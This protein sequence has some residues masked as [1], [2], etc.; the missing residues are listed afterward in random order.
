MNS[1]QRFADDCQL[2][3]LAILLA[4]PRL[5]EGLDL[6][7]NDFPDSECAAL[8]QCLSAHRTNSLDAIA[9]ACG[10]DTAAFAREIGKGCISAPSNLR[11]HI[12]GLRRAKQTMEYA[13]TVRAK[14]G[15]VGR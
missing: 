4:D 9:G 13:Q 8:W 14:L 12:R 10:V 5:I 7:A 15:R 11:R 2:S 6:E 1:L 3:I